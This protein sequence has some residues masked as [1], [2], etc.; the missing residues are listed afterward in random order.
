MILFN[1]QAKSK[2]KKT[3]KQ[4]KK[5]DSQQWI[6]SSKIQIDKQYLKRSY[7]RN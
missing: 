3:T 7:T 6:D 5:P 1:G 4:A 2:K